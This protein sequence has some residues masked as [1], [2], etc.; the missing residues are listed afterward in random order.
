M[1]KSPYAPGLPNTIKNNILAFG[2]LGMINDGNPYPAGSVPPSPIQVFVATSNLF[3]FD[4]DAASM[5]PFYVQGGSTYSGGFPYPEYQSW[6]SNLY[7]RTDGS[8]ASDNQ[9]FH[10]QPNPG[11]G[12]PC[13]TNIAKWQVL[14]FAAWQQEIG[15][16]SQSV[17]RDPGFNHPAYPA[18]D[19]S[20]PNGSPGLGFVVFDPSQAGRS[21]PVIAPPGVAATFPTKTFDPA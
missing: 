7:W 1:P 15:E 21:N 11:G 2:R 14:S 16:D 3:Y 13:T 10:V 17:V 6:N 9:A 12:G 20:L 19:Y 4:R 5:P 8:F 18:D